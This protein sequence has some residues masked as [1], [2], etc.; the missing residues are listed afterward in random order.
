M[1][2]GNEFTLVRVPALNVDGGSWGEDIDGRGHRPR[3]ILFNNICE[4]PTPDG[5]MEGNDIANS[6]R[7]WDDG[8]GRPAPRMT[9]HSFKQL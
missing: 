4:I 5:T 7:H 3:M 6:E 1:F 2:T 9:V 8:G